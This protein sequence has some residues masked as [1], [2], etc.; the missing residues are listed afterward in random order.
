MQNVTK[1]NNKSGHNE[2]VVKPSLYQTGKSTREPILTLKTCRIA[3]NGHKMMK[4]LSIFYLFY[5]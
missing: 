4:G 5:L 3:A 1:L 2:N